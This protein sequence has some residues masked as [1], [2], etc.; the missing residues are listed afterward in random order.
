M[1]SYNDIMMTNSP[2]L[3][4]ILTSTRRVVQIFWANNW[5]ILHFKQWWRR[6]YPQRT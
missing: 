3:L 2:V 1:N 4:G 5:Q 6:F